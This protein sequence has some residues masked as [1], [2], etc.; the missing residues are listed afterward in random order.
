MY[1][2]RGEYTC[3]LK[4]Y[5]LG[6]EGGG[7]E[8][9]GVVLIETDEVPY[10]CPSRSKHNI[11]LPK[12]VN[13]AA[14]RWYLVTARIAG[15]SSDCGSSGQT[16]V[17]TEDQ[18]VFNFRTS[19]KTNNGTDVNSGQ[20]PS[21]LYRVINQ[22]SKLPIVNFD[23]DPVHKVSQHF[24]NSVTKDCF[25]SLITLLKWSWGTFKLTLNDLKDK[26]RFSIRV[27]NYIDIFIIINLLT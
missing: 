10:E 12:T 15:P 1:G 16:S 18:I 17:T 13:L 21:I 11:F 9:D 5:D 25:Q 2:G 3:R 6:M 24:A 7:Y 23:T 27:L 8:K 26:V 22:E 14:N 19:K 20:I 4:V